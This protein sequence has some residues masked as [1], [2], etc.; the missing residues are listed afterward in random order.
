MSNFFLP[1]LAQDSSVK[2]VLD[3]MMRDDF[4]SSKI[5]YLKLLLS[6]MVEIDVLILVNSS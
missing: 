2:I 5:I 3:I 6:F 1:N 4:S